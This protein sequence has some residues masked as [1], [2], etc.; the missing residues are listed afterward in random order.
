MFVDGQEYRQRRLVVVLSTI[1]DCISELCVYMLVF[2]MALSCDQF[3]KINSLRK[4]IF[5]NQ[6]IA[7]P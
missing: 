1:N 3:S 2:N 6:M 5:V 7:S 4:L